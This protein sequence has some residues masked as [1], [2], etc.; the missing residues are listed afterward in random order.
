MAI[1][2]EGDRCR[3]VKNIAGELSRRGRRRLKERRALQ[4]PVERAV[5][6]DEPEECGQAFDQAC[7]RWRRRLVH[8]LLAFLS[9]RSPCAA[10]LLFYARAGT[11]VRDK[12]VLNKR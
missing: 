12:I 3:A 1:E 6:R 2:E 7:V 4:Q 5:L 10:Q 9:R 8:F 11:G